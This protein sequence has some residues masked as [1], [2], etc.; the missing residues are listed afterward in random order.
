[1]ISALFGPPKAVFAPISLL[2]AAF[3]IVFLGR[4]SGITS[5]ALAIRWERALSLLCSP[6]ADVVSFSAALAAS[7][8]LSKWLWALNL[9]AALPRQ[10]I[11]HDATCFYSAAWA[12]Q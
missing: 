3:R 8:R 7:Q 12:L 9:F 10:G 2:R 5:L 11:S 6:N 1:M 4:N